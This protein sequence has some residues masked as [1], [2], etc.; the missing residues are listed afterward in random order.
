M[1]L[2]PKTKRRAFDTKQTIKQF[3]SGS[4]GL[5]RSSLL[6]EVDQHAQA[7]TVSLSSD[8]R[9]PHHTPSELP[10]SSVLSININSPPS[11][12]Q[13]EMPDLHS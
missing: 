9:R 10:M 3:F 7:S 8:D 5:P 4:S 12:R 6:N 11:L 13:P 2:A 1:N